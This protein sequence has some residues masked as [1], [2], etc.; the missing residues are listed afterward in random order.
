LGSLQ[1][2]VFQAQPT[3]TVEGTVGHLHQIRR[4][5]PEVFI[6]EV[7]HFAS[8][9]QWSLVCSEANQGQCVLG[10]QLFADQPP[11]HDRIKASSPTTSEGLRQVHGR[12]SHLRRV[13][14]DEKVHLKINGA[15]S[16]TRR[17]LET[18]FL[19]DVSSFTDL[20]KCSKIPSPLPFEEMY[21]HLSDCTAV[22]QF[23]R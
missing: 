20:Q 23:L 6:L 14:R 9:I 3:A 21:L 22:S 18:I 11:N 17:R 2:P 4:A 13:L 12:D 5:K 15:E 16:G 19:W 10:C 1:S 7:E 8:A